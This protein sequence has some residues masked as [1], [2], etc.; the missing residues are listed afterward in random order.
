[1][2]R[3]LALKNS[4]YS[5]DRTRRFLI[6][7]F[8]SLK[9][10]ILITFEEIL[11]A[12]ERGGASVLTSVTKLQPAAGAHASVSPA[13]FVE[14]GNSVFAFENRY[15]DGEAVKCALIDSKQSQGNRGETAL[16]RDID[17]GSEVIS[18]LPR[19]EVEYADG[20][21]FT[22]LELPH[23]FADGHFRAATIDGKPATQNE[24]YRAVRNSTPVDMTALL[25]TAPIAALL[26]GWDSTRVNNQLRLPSALT[27]E[28]IGVLANQDSES[29][30]QQSKR[31]GARV[32]PYAM[33]VQLSATQMQELL[34]MQRDEL[35]P[36]LVA[37]IEEDIKKNKKGTFS[38]SP[39][40]LGGIP[41]Q[42][43]SLGGVACRQII[44]SWVLSFASLRQLRFG[45]PEDANVAG[46][47]LLAALGLATIARAEQELY[48]RAN[49]HLIESEAPKVK[50]DRRNGESADFEPLTVEAADRILAQA[51]S[52][53]KSQGV[54]D[55]HGQVLKFD[56]NPVVLGAAVEETAEA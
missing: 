45:G 8:V 35:S 50:L 32:D 48:I 44:R 22:D 23:R 33:S 40:G 31:G 42:L 53:A 6:R 37:K 46:R 26:G 36:K 9:G 12:C 47:A 25:N 29:A 11:S 34:D 10:K 38:G 3:S 2:R 14:R 5:H 21:A 19:M 16:Q 4:T 7:T 15:V 49:C 51:I 27:G 52:H 41:P 30:D 55:W 17:A 20:V 39:L 43:E 54:A 56:G 24:Q 18:K 13:K 28:I 1:M